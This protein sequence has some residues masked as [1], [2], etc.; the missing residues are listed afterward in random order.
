[1]WIK[2][3]ALIAHLVLLEALTI[4]SAKDHNSI[5]LLESLKQEGSGQA[6]SIG[7]VI[8]VDGLFAHFEL[9]GLLVE[10]IS[11]G[12]TGDNDVFSP[13]DSPICSCHC[14][15]I[16]INICDLSAVFEHSAVLLRL[17]PTAKEGIP[18]MHHSRIYGENTLDIVRDAECGPALV[19]RASI[20][21]LSIFLELD[22]IRVSFGLHVKQ[23]TS[24][25]HL[26]TSSLLKFIKDLHSLLLH[27]AVALLIMQVAPYTPVTDSPRANG[28]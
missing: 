5:C 11:Q 24:Y 13:V 14:P 27:L 26:V 22:Q 2:V 19:D 8:A 23:A 25:Q 6:H 21:E 16:V 17:V 3:L 20:K 7:E 4:H 12:A 28:P 15:R 1:V 9:I 10:L 18:H